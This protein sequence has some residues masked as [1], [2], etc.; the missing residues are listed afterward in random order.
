MGNHSFFHDGFGT[1]SGCPSDSLRAAQWRRRRV[2]TCAFRRGRHFLDCATCLAL[3]YAVHTQRSYGPFVSCDLT[4]AWI[5]GSVAH[6]CRA[7]VWSILLGIFRIPGLFVT[8][9]GQGMLDFKNFTLLQRLRHHHIYSTVL[10]VLRWRIAAGSCPSIARA[11]YKTVLIGK[12]SALLLYN[13]TCG[14]PSGFFHIPLTLWAA[15]VQLNHY[16]R[17]HPTRSADCRHIV[18]PSLSRS[19]AGV[20]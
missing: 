13:S 9:Y 6:Y 10:F 15:I 18:R 8:P 2:F 11:R 4:F 12:L 7:W 3:R 20:D 5:L 19:S 16:K 14:L 17:C 1:S